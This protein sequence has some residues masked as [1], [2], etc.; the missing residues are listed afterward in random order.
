M[1]S[2][3]SLACSISKA[4]LG[5]SAILI[6]EVIASNDEVIAD[7]LPHGMGAIL[8]YS[9]EAPREEIYLQENI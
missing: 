6:E 1:V 2:R 3:T 9:K 5:I 4:H 7:L 8:E